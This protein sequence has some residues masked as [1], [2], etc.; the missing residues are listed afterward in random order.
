MELLNEKEL[1]EVCGGGSSEI[2]IVNVPDIELRRGNA[3]TLLPDFLDAHAG[4]P[5]DFQ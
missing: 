4:G 2:K 5:V 1:H 3:I